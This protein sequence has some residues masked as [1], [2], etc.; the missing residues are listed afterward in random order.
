MTSN[1]GS[2]FISAFTERGD[3][4]DAKAYDQMKNQITEALRVQFRPE[5]LNRIDEVIVFHALNDADL[6]AIVDMLVADLE[7]RLA[8]Q[9]IVLE[10]TPAARSLIVREGTDPAYGAR[11]LK[12][13]IQRLVENPLARALLRGEFKPGMKV[14]T[15]ADAIGGVLVFRSGDATVVADATAR[16]D[17]RK[18]AAPQPAATAAADR[19]STPGRPDDEGPK[20]VN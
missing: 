17:A 4:G 8:D 5:F 18:R 1:V 9:E 19:I 3:A 14:V 15:D 20:R 12:R 6:A 7:R 10:L 13:T 11:P 2:Q 16:R